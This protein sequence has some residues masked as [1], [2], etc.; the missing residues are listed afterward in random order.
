MVVV[1]FGLAP[2]GCSAV[3]VV[4]KV[5][6][7]AGCKETGLRE[8][9]LLA[10][11]LVL[12]VQGENKK[13]GQEKI[14]RATSANSPADLRRFAS[15]LQ[16]MRGVQGIEEYLK[17]ILEV[18][19]FI[20]YSAAQGEAALAAQSPPPGAI[21]AAPVAAPTAA[22][23]ATATVAPATPAPVVAASR[24]ITADT[25]PKQ[26]DG[27]SV[28][29][30]TSPGRGPCGPL[31]GASATTCVR[32]VDG[33]FVVTDVHMTGE[34]EASVFA[35][36]TAISGIG[37]GARWAVTANARTVVGGGRMFVRGGETLIIGAPDG[38][39]KADARCIVTWGGFRPYAEQGGG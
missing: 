23:F 5:P 10:D 27:G 8:C 12:F 14:Q 13:E 30:L 28:A 25:D 3:D 17:P 9:E 15:F 34:C 33:P 16:S 26:L 24:P 39:A 21:P 37:G 1:A 18:A 11:G 36:A 7:A 6:V 31:L 20:N 22:A 4:V 19:E 35:A 29:P 32:A 38:K 2:T